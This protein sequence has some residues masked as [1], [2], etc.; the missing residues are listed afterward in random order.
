MVIPNKSNKSYLL[1]IIQSQRY[2]VVPLKG[3]QKAHPKMAYSGIHQLIYLRH[4]ERILG[5]SFIQVCEVYTYPPLHILLFHY[6]HI[7][8]PFRVEHFL[9]SPSLL[10]FVHFL[11]DSIRMLFR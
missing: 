7:G 5:A 2:L 9:N 10:K 11:I 4:K 3:V 6:H 8:Q 1:L